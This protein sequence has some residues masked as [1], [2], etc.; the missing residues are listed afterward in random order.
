MNLERIFTTEE[1]PLISVVRTDPQR[2][3]R[4]MGF[5]YKKISRKIKVIVTC[6]HNFMSYP[7][8]EFQFL[9]SGKENP[10]NVISEPFYPDNIAED[11]LFLVAEDSRRYQTAEFELSSKNIPMNKQILYNSKCDYNPDFPTFPF[12]IMYQQ[13]SLSNMHYGIK[14]F[15]GQSESVFSDNEVRKKELRDSGHII[16]PSLWMKSVVGC[17]GSPIFDGNLNLYGMDVRGVGDT[18]QMVYV[19]VSDINKMYRS[20]ESKIRKFFP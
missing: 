20:I 14:T 12:F 4:G 13:V 3:Q 16:Y 2:V 17:S 7:F 11:I 15:D 5:V 6:R 10:L 9:L 8:S 18:D 1:N 19:P